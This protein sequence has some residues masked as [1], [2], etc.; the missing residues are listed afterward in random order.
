MI[1]L[2]INKTTNFQIGLVANL[3]HHHTTRT[4]PTVVDP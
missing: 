1:I 4:Q 2:R 3:N